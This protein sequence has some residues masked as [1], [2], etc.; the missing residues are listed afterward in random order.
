MPVE[1]RAANDVVSR[2]SHCKALSGEC[3]RS[4]LTRKTTHS[5]N[6]KPLPCQSFCHNSRKQS[7]MPHPDAVASPSGSD[8][9]KSRNTD[10]A[11]S[12]A[13]CL[14]FLSTCGDPQAFLYGKGSLLS[15][16]PGMKTCVALA[17][18]LI[19]G[20]WWNDVLCC[21]QL[22]QCSLPIRCPANSF[23]KP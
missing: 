20:I 22:V 9:E 6:L 7:S 3:W 5:C 17:R 18:Q 21:H 23:I 1:S 2:V 12:E 15:K 14:E 4:W 11:R 8:Q 10:E 16:Q 13:N 19:N